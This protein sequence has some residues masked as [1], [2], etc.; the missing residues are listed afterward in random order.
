MSRTCFGACLAGIV[1]TALGR[2]AV[3]AFTPP[4][5]N[6]RIAFARYAEGQPGGEPSGGA[7]FTI[8]TNGREERRVTRPPAGACD[9]QPDCSPDGSRIVFE[10]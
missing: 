9:T 10:R 6:G 2:L 5:K 7:I 4:E 1:T 8:G 3:S